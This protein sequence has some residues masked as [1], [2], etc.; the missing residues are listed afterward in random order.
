MVVIFKAYR[1]AH[2]CKTLNILMAVEGSVVAAGAE[3]SAWEAPDMVEAIKNMC[4]IS[5]VP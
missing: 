2:A 5:K 3:D 1:R 4:K